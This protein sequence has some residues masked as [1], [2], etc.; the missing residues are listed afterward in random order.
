[1]CVLNYKTE[2]SPHLEQLLNNWWFVCHFINTHTKRA[3]RH[4]LL[5]HE[6]WQ[7]GV[8]CVAHN[9]QIGT[10]EY[11]TFKIMSVKSGSLTTAISQEIRQTDRLWLQV[12]RFSVEP[13]L[14]NYFPVYTDFLF[15]TVEGEAEMP[16]REATNH[17]RG[18]MKFEN[19]VI[20]CFVCEIPKVLFD[21]RSLH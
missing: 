15:T 4:C 8:C 17:L 7:F 3:L 13:A 16:G 12:I 1:M 9:T 10:K 14:F 6:N 2:H 11:D 20:C 5:W 19:D 21:L 18:I